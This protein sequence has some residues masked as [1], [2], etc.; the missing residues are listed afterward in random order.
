[1][2]RFQAALEVAAG[3]L[4]F[5]LVAVGAIQ[6]GSRYTGVLFVPWTEELGRLLFVWV[7]WIGAAAAF[8]RGSHIRFDFILQRLPVR[9]R[10]YGDVFVQ[11]GVAIFLLVLVRYG[12]EVAQAQA[13]SSFLT[14]NLSVRY[15]YLSSVV[16]AALM[17][18]A[19]GVTARERLRQR[20]ARP[21]TK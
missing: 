2:R 9:L 14:L 15:T 20:T 11:V 13:S 6:V 19:L 18:F 4:L 16:G 5:V 12:F 3:F 10:V 17:L 7:V 1:M 8:V 21:E